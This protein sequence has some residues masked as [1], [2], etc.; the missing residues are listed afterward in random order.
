MRDDPLGHR[1]RRQRVRTEG[2]HQPLQADQRLR[3]V[4]PG[5]RVVR[6]Q[7]HG[8]ACRNAQYAACHMFALLHQD[9]SP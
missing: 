3:Q 7:D 9:F 2:G 1:L 8:C 4:C 6:L 5:A